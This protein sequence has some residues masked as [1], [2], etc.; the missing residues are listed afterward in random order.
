MIKFIKKYLIEQI[1][2]IVSN[3]GFII[4]RT[5]FAKFVCNILCVK[6]TVV[7]LGENFYIINK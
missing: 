6:K 3:D 5:L 1:G 4:T 2:F 7:N